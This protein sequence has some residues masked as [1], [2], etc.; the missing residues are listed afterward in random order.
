[1]D[2]IEVDD[3]RA[4]VNKEP[5]WLHCHP[6]YINTVLEIFGWSRD[7]VVIEQEFPATY[8]NGKFYCSIRKKT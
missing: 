6:D 4:V 8:A 3:I 7:D 5:S 1:M 2:K